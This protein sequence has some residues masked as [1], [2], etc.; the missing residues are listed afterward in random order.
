MDKEALHIRM[1]PPEDSL[2]SLGLICDAAHNE[3]EKIFLAEDI[4][5]SVPDTFSGPKVRLF[6]G[7]V[8]ECK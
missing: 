1:H 2:R 8:W 3:R 5:V 6:G 7:F 4:G